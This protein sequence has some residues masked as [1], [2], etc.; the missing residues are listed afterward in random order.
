MPD[1]F[2]QGQAPHPITITPAARVD[3]AWKVVSHLPATQDTKGRSLL[4]S[5]DLPKGSQLLTTPEGRSNVWGVVS[6]MPMAAV[7]G[8]I[9]VV[10]KPG[11]IA[12]AAT[13]LSQNVQRKGSMSEE[14]AENARAIGSAEIKAGGD[15][16]MMM[17][18]GGKPERVAPETGAP[19]F[20]PHNYDLMGDLQRGE[21]T[22]LS[23]KPE[24]VQK[25]TKEMGWD[26]LTERWKGLQAGG[27][28]TPAL[29]AARNA[30]KVI[31]NIASPETVDASAQ[32]AAAAIREAT[33]TAARDSA[34]TTAALEPAWKT[35]NAL[36]TQD[37]LNFIDYVEG[38]SSKFSG[39]QM[40][41][42]ALQD[43]AN[44]MKGAFDKRMAKLQALP[45]TAQLSF[46]EDY[47][48]HMW[49]DP[50]K[51]QQFLAGFGKQGSGG[52]TKGRTLPTVADGLAAGLEPLT[53][54]PI[55][56]TIRY[57]TN[58]DR[59]IA[60][61]EVF[62][63]ARNLGTVNYR[64]PGKQLPGEV[65]LKGRLGKRTTPAGPQVAYAPE[66]WARVY[67]NYISRGIA[68]L[69]PALQQ[70][71]DA[72]RHTANA[73]TGLELSLSGY[74]TMT[75][76]KAALD[77]SLSQAIYLA[78][79]GK[80]IEAIKQV[81]KTPF[82]PVNYARQG[83][84]VKEVYL[85][86]RPGTRELEGIVDELTKAGGRVA[87]RDYAPEYEFSKGGDYWKAFKRGA[88]KLQLA[89]DRA[90]AMG[91]PVGAA[92]VG[93]RH[94][95]RIMDTIAAPLFDKY[96]PAV[97]AGA[98][99]ENLANWMKVHPQAAP[100][101]VTKAAR[102]IWD[103]M[104]DR[105]GEMVQDNIF[106]NKF[107]K[108][109]G[110]VALRSWSWSVG[111][112]VRMLGG[113]ARDVVR[114]PFKRPTGI[115]PNDGRWTQKM[116]MAIAM[117]IVYGTL[118]M[119]YQLWKTGE[120]PESAQDLMAPK[121]GGIDAATGEPERLLMPGPEKDVFGMYE[122]PQQEIGNKV[123]TGPRQVWDLFWNSDWR[124]DPNFS[125]AEEAPPWY[126]QFWNYV[127]DN[128]GPISLRNLAKGRKDDS[129]VSLGE[130][131]LGA[132]TAPRYL[133]DPEGYEDMMKKIHGSQWKTKERHDRAQQRLYD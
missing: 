17:G 40:K 24:G 26:D 82:A 75:V 87:G 108:Q 113:A 107:I 37:R 133:T 51:A 12:S 16:A 109:L 98:F 112:D 105:F 117:P 103:S 73:I 101:E 6:Q 95:G 78:R 1:D 60:Q 81:A 46:I 10:K 65:E 58:A 62:D 47:Y 27:L 77:N 2:W 79:K 52:F 132:R 115:A 43:L 34:K 127:T 89:A 66:G 3:D 35:V 72:V 99:K 44:T 70:G 128:F 19:K 85:G 39:L 124:G 121:T 11:E 114:A 50:Q 88:L 92:K 100:E 41:D 59:F 126:T 67:N 28:A 20:G 90:E 119:M 33:G 45:S 97:K 93:A 32:N 106:M 7:K 22:P 104:D 80:P 55:A 91:S 96:I 122:N 86:L 36:P 56:A 13:D 42:P 4:P 129:N 57:V 21:I 71:Y 54:D 30:G 29:D 64:T 14:D 69:D 48:P 23:A 84:T 63:T 94:V 25:F 9:D 53:T 8:A 15:I 61:N 111:Q 38:R 102:Q 116:D 76:A 49:K 83:G 131:L 74:H 120:G 31:E 125:R 110:T 123:G 5:G 130:Q 68:E 18:G 118:S